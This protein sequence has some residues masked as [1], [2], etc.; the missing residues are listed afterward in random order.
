MSLTESSAPGKGH[1]FRRVCCWL[2]HSRNQ[3]I[4]DQSKVLLLRSTYPLIHFDHGPIGAVVHMGG[5]G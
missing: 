3:G 5:M 2:F 4:A 1:G